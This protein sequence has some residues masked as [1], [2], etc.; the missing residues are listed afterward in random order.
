VSVEPHIDIVFATDSPKAVILR[1]GP[2]DWVH[3]LA[4]DTSTD[5]VTR[6]AWFHG[7]I[8]AS[9]CSLSPDGELL[10]YFATCHRKTSRWPFGFAWTA[11]SKP[12]WLTALVRWTQSTTWAGGGTFC[13]NNSV[14]LNFSQWRNW[15]L[16]RGHIPKSFTILFAPKGSSANSAP[17]PAKCAYDNAVGI[18]H[19]GLGF[20]FQDSCLV[21]QH[22]D[23]VVKIIDLSNMSPDP[24]PS[25]QC[26]RV[27]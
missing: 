27:W 17:L 9:R 16:R 14:L 5:V 15:V 1:R 10:I 18:D 11:I 19:Q 25:P 4:W 26:A 6:G 20:A 24:Q 13:G 22:G 23:K 2:S 8:Y 7:R 12:P 3:V 21:R